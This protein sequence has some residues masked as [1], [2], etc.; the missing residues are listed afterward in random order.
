[1]SVPVNQRQ[2]N[3]T[4]ELWLPGRNRSSSVFDFEAAGFSP[5]VAKALI[6][7]FVALYGSTTL[8]SQRATWVQVKRFAGYVREKSGR[9]GVLPREC[10]VGFDEWLLN[11]G[12][13]AKSVGGTHNMCVRLL[14]WCLRNAPEVVDPRIELIRSPYAARSKVAK[15][16]S[17]QIPDE[18]LV[19]RILAACYQDIEAVDQRLLSVRLLPLSAEQAEL[20]D[21]LM[22]LLIIGQGVL[23][24]KK[25]MLAARGGRMASERLVKYGA[26]R[27]VQAKYDL[28][29][30]DIFPFYLAILIQTSGNPMALLRAR[31]DCIVEVPLRPELERIVWDKERA[32]REQAPDFPRDKA[33]S[34]PNIVRRLLLL[35]A[36]L[37]TVASASDADALFLCRNHHSRVVRPSWQSV[38]DALREFRS[39]HGLPKFDLRVF[40]RAGAKMHHRASRSLAAAKHRLQH[41]DV[42]T[43]QE[44]TPL[45]DLRSSHD[46]VILRFQGLLLKNALQSVAA[47]ETSHRPAVGRTIEAPPVETTFGFEC[48]DPTG[49][50][51]PGSRAG[52]LCTRFTQCA[53]CPGAMVVVDDPACV[54]RLLRTRGHLLKEHA[55]ALS[56]G[57]SSRFDQLYGPTLRILNS[58]VLPAVSNHTL[59]E[60]RAFLGSPLPRLE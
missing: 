48:R 38:H 1:M 16:A 4:L 25:V 17:S 35:N 13:S 50:I 8:E 57:W 47:G 43:T 55:R 51:A 53:T 36:D 60:A 19:R 59:E 39:R 44:Y 42:R 5:R 46:G 11:R 14:R 31:R 29:I 49:G 37:R 41:A 32:C 7:A 34:A 9:P 54:A 21:L 33:W 27:G 23:P 30:E 2:A 58:E 22:Q 28:T 6:R 24:A 45:T 15:P 20:P 3:G 18:P 52:E 40:R 56:E 10:I 26:L 12:F